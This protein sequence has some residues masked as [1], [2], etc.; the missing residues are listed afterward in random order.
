[1]IKYFVLLIAILLNGCLTVSDKPLSTVGE[2]KLDTSLVGSWRWNAEPGSEGYLHIGVD[3]KSAKELRFVLIDFK[4]SNVIN[5][6]ELIG[7]TTE[8]ANL[9][10]M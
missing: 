9:L 3:Q 10:D 4:E 8:H 1:M 6:V 5:I 7:H 2:D